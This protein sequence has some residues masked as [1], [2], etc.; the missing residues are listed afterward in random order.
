[1]RKAG[2]GRGNGGF[3]LKAQRRIESSWLYARHIGR[4]ES[5]KREGEGTTRFRFPKVY[6]REAL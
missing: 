4:M 1:M 5:R 3:N 2:G 6:R